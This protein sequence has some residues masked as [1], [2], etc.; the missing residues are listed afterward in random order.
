MERQETLQR[1]LSRT[2]TGSRS[3]WSRKS[4]KKTTSVQLSQDEIPPQIQSKPQSDKMIEEGKE[5]WDGAKE[6]PDTANATP[7]SRSIIPDPL[8]DVPSWYNK[9][10]LAAVPTYRM[11]Y[12]IHNPFGPRWYKN[13][14]LIPHS[15]TR[16]PPS[17]FS[18]SFPSLPPP[19][20]ERSEDQSRMAGPSRTPS[21]S[22]LPTPTSSQT[23]I[24]E[25]GGMPRSRKTS[26]TA[27]D[28]V[29]LLDV[30][31]P[32]GTNWH[33]HSP[34]DIGL[35]ANAAPVESNEVCFFLSRIVFSNSIVVIRVIL[36]NELGSQILLLIKIVI[37]RCLHR[38]YH[39]LRLLSIF[40]HQIQMGLIFPINSVNAANPCLGVFLVATLGMLTTRR[41]RRYLSPRAHSTLPFL[42]KALMTSG[43][44]RDPIQ[45]YHLRRLAWVVH[46]YLRATKAGSGLVY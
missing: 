21:G 25:S 22:P 41:Q 5:K 29:D 16:P 2:K 8:R 36:S 3:I 12:P 44:R 23:G 46:Q 14:H 4:L 37:K 24:A 18:P 32:W 35:T 42:H 20:H 6:N 43:K 38:L 31:D 1:K 15:Q 13:H 30:T 10:A 39:S 9:E 19:T 17:V 28:P 40:R 11:K 33:H 27:H 26:Q 34:Y 7:L 45:H